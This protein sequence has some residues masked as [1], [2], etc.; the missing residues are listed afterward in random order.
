M[1]YFSDGTKFLN[2]L[3]ALAYSNSKNMRAQF[4][5]YDHIYSNLNWKVEPPRQLSEYYKEQ[6]QRIRD[7]HDYVIL[8]YSGG[9][10][11][12]NILETFYYNNIKL[13]KII[14]TGA[15]SQD[16][17]Y[18]TDENR[19]AEIYHNCIPYI[20][21][22]GLESIYEI[23]DHTKEFDK[24][25]S[26]ALGLYKDDWIEKTGS[27]FSP[28][29]WFWKNV[30]ST[31]LRPELKNKKVALVFGRDKPSIR[32]YTNSDSLCFQ[33]IDT[34]IDSYGKIETID[35]LNIVNFYWDHTHPDILL[36]QL[37]TMRNIIKRD[38]KC[39]LTVDPTYGVQHINGTSVNSIVYD[40]KV[41]LTYMSPKSKSTILSLRD[42]Y[43][44]KGINSE[45]L[46][47]YTKGIRNLRDRIGASKVP[48][49]ESIP[50]YL[51]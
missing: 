27:W 29:N 37:H 32:K 44:L 38:N 18:G 31:I 11:S 6:A 39:V 19:N 9:H 17:T 35:N 24:L 5:F 15:F 40:L 28:H 51:D 33:F 34:V 1:Y 47:V 13:D 8:C 45:V 26:N 23:I 16:S 2:K 21:Y 46:S 22:L 41:P 14:S 10:D 30:H 20:K 3:D 50:Y 4:Y 12:T 48:F 36:K 7:S 49:I 43:L 42:S 25:E